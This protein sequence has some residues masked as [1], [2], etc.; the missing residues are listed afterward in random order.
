[1]KN[2]CPKCNTEVDSI[3]GDCGCD[4]FKDT[5]CKDCGST[6]SWFSDVCPCTGAYEQP[7]SEGEL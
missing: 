7:I 1:M 3:A 5:I 4:K 2:I 6:L